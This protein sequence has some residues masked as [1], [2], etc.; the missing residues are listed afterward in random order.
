MDD[1]RSTS[2]AL[3]ISK[4]LE[5]LQQLPGAQASLR[6]ADHAQSARARID[7]TIDLKLSGRP[8]LLVVEAKRSVFPRDT[9]ET[10]WQLREYARGLNSR[11]LLIPV[12]A[13]ESISPGSKELLKEENVG[14]F[15]MGGSLF[16][17]ADGAYVYI[18]KPAPK[19][20]ARSVTGVFKGK[21]SQVVF[22]L[23]HHN[24][25]WFGVN[26]L[27]KAARASSATVSET[28]TVLDRFEWVETRGQ[29]PS[30]E[31]RLTAPRPLLDEWKKQ[32]LA[33]PKPKTHRY[34]VPNATNSEAFERRL[35]AA[36]H[37]AGVSYVQ[38]GEAAAQHYAPFLTSVSRVACRAPMGGSIDVALSELGAQE[39]TEGVNFTI[40]DTPEDAGPFLFKERRG[41]TWLASPIQ[42]YLDLLIVGGRAS[43][44]A[45][46]LRRERIG[47]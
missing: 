12:L 45:D 22:V 40:I 18:D 39:V 11:D 42:V 30:K 34:Y 35:D 38:T 46:H 1:G 5:T 19:N 8:V 41:S 2:E 47:F 17:P 16:L 14:Y 10:L 4:L 15:D 32:I 44:A 9:R 36:F 28:L 27:A 33:G 29:G 20:F 25:Q 13:A 6:H 43:E 23:L 3:V 37:K 26:D 21:R 24:M 31:R 7:A